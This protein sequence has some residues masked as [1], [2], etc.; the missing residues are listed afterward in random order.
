MKKKKDLSLTLF[1]GFGVAIAVAVYGLLPVTA[2]ADN[3][4]FNRIATFPV[5]LNTDINLE[6]VAEIID[7]SKDGKT[8]VYTD[9]Q[10]K[11]LGF[12]DIKKP[13]Q[14]KALGAIDVGG[15]PTSV[16]VAGRFALV[17]VNT[18]PDFVAPSGHLHVV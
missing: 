17:A 3:R 14:P 11:K 15:E 18:A 1:H 6:T 12:V 8:L 4:V 9:S 16:A 2:N 10:T 5:Y 13:D 7:A